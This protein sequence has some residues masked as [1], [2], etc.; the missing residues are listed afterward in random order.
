MQ[1]SFTLRSQAPAVP[2]VGIPASVNVTLVGTRPASLHLTVPP[3]L[4]DEPPSCPELLPLPL[5]D[6][7]LVPL[8]PLLVL[9]ELDPDDE[10]VEEEEL[11]LDEPEDDPPSSSVYPWLEPVPHA[12]RPAATATAARATAHAA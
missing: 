11:P 9:P 10:D 5:P 7:L 6:P 3:L 2:Q 1:Q 4:E 8:L 12:A